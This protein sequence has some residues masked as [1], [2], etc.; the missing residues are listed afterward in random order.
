M[1]ELLK[2]ETLKDGDILVSPWG[3]EVEVMDI[4][5]QH[6][7]DIYSAG[8]NPSVIE[9]LDK[10]AFETCFGGWKAKEK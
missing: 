8:E 5:S 1:S 3:T 9:D 7:V 4:C 10:Y 6:W 2:L